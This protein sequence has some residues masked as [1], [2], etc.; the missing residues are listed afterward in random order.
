ME[1]IAT[2]GRLNKHCHSNIHT[3]YTTL[4]WHVHGVNPPSLPGYLVCDCFQLQMSKIKLPKRHCTRRYVYTQEMGP[5]YSMVHSLMIVVCSRLLYYDCHSTLAHPCRNNYCN[6]ECEWC[7][8]FLAAKC[9]ACYMS[10]PSVIDIASSYSSVY[11]P[12]P[13]CNSEDPSHMWWPQVDRR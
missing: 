10:C 11:G 12:S 4:R 2:Q 6:T 5:E 9:L 7:V 8:E 3:Q 1:A 13:L